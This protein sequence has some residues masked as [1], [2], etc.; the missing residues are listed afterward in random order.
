MKL[1][2]TD[3]FYAGENIKAPS[4]L[5]VGAGNTQAAGKRRV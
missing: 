4:F 3:F 2:L 5:S 1:L